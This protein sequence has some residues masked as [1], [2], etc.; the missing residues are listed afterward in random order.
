MMIHEQEKLKAPFKNDH[1]SVSRLNTYE[2]CPLKL[3]LSYVDG[4]K[5]DMGKEPAELGSLVHRVME[6]IYHRAVEGRFFGKVPDRGI[7][8]CYRQAFE[9]S[10]VIGD[11]QYREGLG[12]VR[13]YLA[14]RDIDYRNV[15]GIEKEFRLKLDEF[16]LLGYI[17]RID[18]VDNSTAKV[19]DYKT[20]RYLFSRDDIAHDLQMSAYGL[21][22]IR[23]FDWAKYVQYEFEMLRHN[24]TLSTSRTPDQ[25]MSA[26]N[27]MVS[28]GRRIES[29]EH[30]PARL[31][32]FCPWCDHRGVCHAY[33][34]ALQRGEGELRFQIASDD[35]ER[36]SAERE[37]AATLE[38]IA[39]K[40]KQEVDRLLA[41]HVS[42][43]DPE[44]GLV[45]GT[46]RYK[47]VQRWDA[48]YPREETVKLL[49]QELA[50]TPESVAQRLVKVN[51]SSIQSFLRDARI[52]SSK[53]QVIN[54]RLQ[55]IADRA[56]CKPYISSS[57]LFARR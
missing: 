57:E 26:A 50:L 18:R 16:E 39:K 1:L 10:N 23:L 45:V 5:E 29:A 30:M 14:G 32:Q 41:P 38:R 17:D 54:L 36:L 4:R 6:L 25:L 2:Q 21:A 19:V 33:L 49:A 37:R 51:S 13:S 22:V 46:R 27:Y 42:R 55:Q 31:N 15:I 8:R 53:R 47:M 20:S 7:I 52:S 28:L 3:K 35:V 34:D 12:M 44:E 40:R 11:D 24:V 56:P 43:C 48:D 9:D